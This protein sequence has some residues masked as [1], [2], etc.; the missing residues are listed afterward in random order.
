[1]KGTNR[2]NRVAFVL[3]GIL[4]ISGSVL[5]ATVKWN[6]VSGDWAA[7]S[8]WDVGTKPTVV[9]TAYINNDGTSTVT[10]V[11]TVANL[12]IGAGHCVVN[13]GNLTVSSVTKFTGASLGTCTLEGGN[14]SLSQLYIPYDSG[15]RGNFIQ[16]GGTNEISVNYFQIPR[17]GTGSYILNAGKLISG[18]LKIGAYNNGTGTFTQVGG[19]YTNSGIT[20]GEY[21]GSL[22]TYNLTNGLLSS[23]GIYVGSSGVGFF[24]QYGGTNRLQYEKAFILGSSV[25]GIGTYN[26]YGGELFL[27]NGYV[28]V[29][30]SGNGTVNQT[31]GIYSN[32]SEATYIGKSAN[33][34]GT[35]N[36]SG[37]RIFTRDFYLG[38]KGSGSFYQSG[39]TNTVTRR[40]RIGASAGGTG[41]YEMSG[42]LLNVTNSQDLC[43]GYDTTG[44]GTFVQVGGAVYAGSTL[45]VGNQGAHGTYRL[46]GGTLAMAGSEYIY[47]GC[48]FIQTG[49]VHNIGGSLHILSNGV[50]RGWGDVNANSAAHL[51]MNGIIVADGYGFDHTLF[52]TNYDY[53]DRADANGSEGTNGY[54]AVNHGKLMLA[55]FAT[56]NTVSHWGGQSGQDDLVNSFSMH[57]DSRTDDGRLSGVLYATNNTE[58][59]VFDSSAKI[60]GIWGLD[61]PVDSV[62]VQADITFRYDHIAAALQ[63][64]AETDL[65]IYC[66]PGGATDSWKQVV[67][68][69]VDI[70]NNKITASN[71]TDVTAFFAVG[72]SF[73]ESGTVTN[74]LVR[75]G[76]P[77]AVATFESIGIIYNYEGDDNSNADCTVSYTV[78]GS[79]NWQNSLPVWRDDRKWGKIKQKQFRVSLLNLK[80]DTSYD[81]KIEPQDPDGNPA[82]SF[83]TVK[84]WSE[85]FPIAETITIS[86]DAL[87]NG[88]TV[89]NSG[90]AEGYILYKTAY[91][92][93][94]D[95]TNGADTCI[96]ITKTVHHIILKGMTMKGARKHA[97]YVDGRFS[98]DAHDIVIEN[99]DISNW[100]S[101]NTDGWGINMQCAIYSE[102]RT[103]RRVIVQRNIIHHPRSDSNNW[104]EPR[105]AY[106]NN[107]HPAGPQAVGFW[108]SSGNHVIRYNHIYSD[109][110]HYYNDILGCGANFGQT[111]FPANDTDIYGNILENCWDDAVESEGANLNVRIWGN[112]IENA[113][114]ALSTRLT[115]YGPLYVWRNVCIVGYRAPGNQI[116]AAFH[117]SGGYNTDFDNG[118]YLFH[119]TAVLPPGSEIEDSGTRGVWGRMHYIT[120]ANNIFNTE[121]CITCEPIT[122][123]AGS[124]FLNDLC[125]ETNVNMEY[126]A[127]ATPI[128]GIA[129]FSSEFGLNRATGKGIF[130]QT[131]DSPGYNSGI[132]ITNF[133]SDIPDGQPDLGAHEA[134]TP[135]MEFGPKAYL[136][137]PSFIMI[138]R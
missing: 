114:Q 74:E 71:I 134:G 107:P 56:E 90:T 133:N 5:A 83:L 37:G 112:Y 65:K 8:N 104:E 31:S 100:G 70:V 120:T 54:Y 64:I 122:A 17:R 138:I 95:V 4:L 92:S 93:T 59:P 91:G 87:H 82:P 75:F 32:T 18:T 99:C 117:K 62:D 45:S 10:T 137:R 77:S 38:Y 80:P 46:G 66:N 55:D 136:V 67:S 11:E 118:V 97:I 25:A 22:G 57:F 68:Y 43:V 1:M 9:D 3:T 26:L 39:G 101:T 124:R 73:P 69:G 28:A 6:A 85:T 23:R 16:N 34:E 14:M 63:G 111:G 61:D 81:I 72:D 94:I 108:D 12:T 132:I 15:Q 113:F 119:N 79:T 128:Q 21:S 50:F 19:I 7:G 78:S 20:I 88:Y 51:Y 42:G 48:T 127:E 115:V 89:T 106:K 41:Y 105:P 49:G 58:V 53:V 40:C 52:I 110:D 98:G 125:T 103:L 121:K 86:G 123:A 109:A 96:F 84:T 47:S 130:Y 30:L 27:N 116:A 60:I 131:S 44:T 36:L 129:K 102:N 35:Y 24:N 2:K 29:G 33:S 135:P 13:A 126:A 76:I